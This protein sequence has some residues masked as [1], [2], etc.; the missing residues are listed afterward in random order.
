MGWVRRKERSPAPTWLRLW[1]KEVVEDRKQE[2]WTLGKMNER[3]CSGRA[4]CNED[5]ETW[6]VGR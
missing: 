5:G 3:G 1:M 4:G 2:A 6:I